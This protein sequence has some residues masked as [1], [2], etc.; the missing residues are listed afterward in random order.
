MVTLV[1]GDVDTAEVQEKVAQYFGQ[2]YK[3]QLDIILEKNIN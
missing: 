3:N 2:E 1:I